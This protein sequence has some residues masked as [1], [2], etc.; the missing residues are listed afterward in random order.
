MLRLAFLRVPSP[1]FSFSICPSP[2]RSAWIEPESLVGAHALFAFARLLYFQSR[3]GG[4]EIAAEGLDGAGAFTAL[5]LAPCLPG[6][7]HGVD[8]GAVRCADVAAVA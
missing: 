7:E 6:P 8:V 4:A 5:R 3:H 1:G 2:A